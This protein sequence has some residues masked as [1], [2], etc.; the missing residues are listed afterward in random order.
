VITGTIIGLA[1]YLAV[2]ILIGWFSSRRIRTSTDFIVAG[3]R[4]PLWILWATTFATFWCAG[5]VMGAAEETYNGGIIDVI[6]D[7][8]GGGLCLILTGVFFIRAMRRMKCTTP[9]D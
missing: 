4:L 8:Y 1:I 5:V 3:R 7:P 9:S 2:C 6:A